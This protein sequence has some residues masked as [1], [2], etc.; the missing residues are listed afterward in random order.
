KSTDYTDLGGRVSTT[1]SRSFRVSRALVVN[2]DPLLGTVTTGFSPS[3]FREVGQ[4][5][6]VTATALPPTTS[7]P[8]DGA[9]FTG[10]TLGGNDVAKGG[11]AFTPQRLGLV[12]SALGKPTLSFI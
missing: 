3:S 5:F 4:K 6:S 11:I 1:V 12:D 10:W 9:L 8:F 2:A 7:P